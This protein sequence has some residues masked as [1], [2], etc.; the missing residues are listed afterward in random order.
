MLTRGQTRPHEAQ[1]E[2]SI[3]ELW[4][5]ASEVG[6]GGEPNLPAPWSWTSSIQSG[7]KVC[8]VV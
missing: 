2:G 7:E 4:R 6:G 5:K 1:P 8:A 3:C